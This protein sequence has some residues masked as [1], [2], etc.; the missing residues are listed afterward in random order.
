[1]VALC[2]DDA[3]EPSALAGAGAAVED[4]LHEAAGSGRAGEGVAQDREEDVGGGQLD[5]RVERRDAERG[6][7]VAS[8]RPVLAVLLQKLQ[9]GN[10]RLDAKSRSLQRREEPHCAEPLA[11]RN[12]FRREQA[13]EE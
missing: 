12:A 7:E 9:K 1:M 3:R 8:D 5:R 2:A 6:P 10:I 13:A 4:P 11:E